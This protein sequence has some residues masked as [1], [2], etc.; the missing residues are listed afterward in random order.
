MK[1]I[2]NADDFG[3]TNAVS[4]CIIELFKAGTPLKSTSVMI[5]LISD[6]SA[7][8]LKN[9]IKHSKNSFSA[10]LHFNLTCGAPISPASKISSIIDSNGRFLKFEDLI[11]RAA[12]KCIEPAHIAE[13]FSAQYNTFFEKTGFYPS[14]IDSHKHIHMLP[15]F[16]KTVIECLKS[17]V[18][19][20]IRLA[21]NISA[22]ELFISQGIKS[23]IVSKCFVSEHLQD[24]IS[25]YSRTASAAGVIYPAAF[26]GTYSVGS[27]NSNFFEKEVIPFSPNNII[28]EYMTHPGIC[29]NSLK[30][31]SSLTLP[32]ESEYGALKSAELSETLKKYCIA[33]VSFNEL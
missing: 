27:L 13:E 20:R 5:N 24:G 2:F 22:I 23:D 31:L 25:Y 9:F 3:I 14:H 26:L 29:D 19:K 10:G 6:S 12:E 17:M 4:N 7:A 1:V 21:E 11:L 32:R 33:P 30:A 8:L 28:C 18:T 16:F 15:V